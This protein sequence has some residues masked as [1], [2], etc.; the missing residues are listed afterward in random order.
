MKR[1]IWVIL[2]SGEKLEHRE[3]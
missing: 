1:I 3:M 2:T